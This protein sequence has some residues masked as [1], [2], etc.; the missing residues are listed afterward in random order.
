ML[1]KDKYISYWLYFILVRLQWHLRIE[2]VTGADE[3]LVVINSDERHR[4]YQA[5]QDVEVSSFDCA[6]PIRMYPGGQDR[7]LFNASKTF[8]VV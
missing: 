2:F 8:V 1:I 6:I 3:P 7:A 5:V 4:H